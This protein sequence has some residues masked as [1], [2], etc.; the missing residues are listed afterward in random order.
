[1]IR[2][3]DLKNLPLS[4]HEGEGAGTR[5]LSNRQQ[6]VFWEGRCCQQSEQSECLKLAMWG[7]HSSLAEGLQH[8]GREICAL[9]NLLAGQM[10]KKK[11]QL[12]E[13][14]PNLRRAPPSPSFAHRSKTSP[15]ANSACKGLSVYVSPL[16]C[17]LPSFAWRWTTGSCTPAAVQQTTTSNLSR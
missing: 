11:V 6:A 12:H 17:C 13:N 2:L 15:S 7:T 8:V 14:E 1:M 4:F 10:C 9:L 16:S 3:S 5:Q